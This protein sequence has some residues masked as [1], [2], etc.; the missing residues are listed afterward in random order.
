MIDNTINLYGNK[1][2]RGRLKSNLTLSN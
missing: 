2:K 1:Q